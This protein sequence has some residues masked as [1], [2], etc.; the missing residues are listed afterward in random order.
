[1]DIISNHSRTLEMQQCFTN[2]IERLRGENQQL[3]AA[4]RQAEFRLSTVEREK[5]CQQAALSEK[6]C[7]VDQLTS[8]KQ[9]MTAELGVWRMQL[10][11]LKAEGQE[12]LKELLGGKTCELEQENLKLQSQ[13]KTLRAELDQTNSSL[14]TLEA[15]DGHGLKVALGMQK[16][17][18]SKREQIDFLQSRIQLLDETIEKLKMEKHRQALLVKRQTQELLSERESRRRLESE[19][20]AL[21]SKERELKGK[22]ERLEAALYKMSDSFAE[23][24]DFIQKQEQELMRLKLQH[25]L[26]IKELQSQ[27]WRTVSRSPVSSCILQTHIPLAQHNV[28]GLMEMRVSDPRVELKSFLRDLRGGIAEEKEHTTL[29][30][31][32]KPEEDHKSRQPIGTKGPESTPRPVERKNSYSEPGSFRTSEPNKQD[33]ANPLSADNNAVCF[34][35]G[36]TCCSRSVCAT[37]R[38]SPVHLLLTSDLPTDRNYWLEMERPAYA[39]QISASNQ[40]ELTGQ[41]SQKIKL[42]RP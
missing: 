12:A 30:F 20:E 23:C 39:N 35:A 27:N 24:Q 1:M 3:K 37:G 21:C 26:D 36:Q 14:R 33:H 42:D 38:R 13:L 11:L 34:R 18:T 19:V 4:L 16:Q 28:N 6:I 8:E 5:A 9:Q 32:R 29:S 10:T 22:A 2:Q 31:R 40:D 41:A 15:A 25:T 7:N 17:I